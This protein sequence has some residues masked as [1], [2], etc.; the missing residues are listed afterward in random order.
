MMTTDVPF[1][2]NLAAKSQLGRLVDDKYDLDTEILGH[3]RECAA[4]IVSHLNPSYVVFVGRSLESIQVYLDGVL[5]DTFLSDSLINLNIS[6]FNH[7][8]SMIRAK[9]EMYVVALKNHFANIGLHPQA[10]LERSNFTSFVDVVLEGSTFGRI[11]KFLVEWAKE[12]RVDVPAVKKKLRFIGIISRS[13]SSPNAW[14]W[15]DHVD[16]VGEIPG[17]VK[18]IAVEL[19]FWRY[20]GE[21]QDKMTN[22]ITLDKWLSPTILSPVHEKDNI[23]ALNQAYSIYCL[24]L[25]KRERKVFSKAVAKLNL[26]SRFHRKLI[27]EV[28]G[29]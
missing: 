25:D 15:N 21:V 20:L 17:S 22:S 23:K 9:G 27:L 3:V 18:N 7:S 10:I 11:Y 4:N 8:I 16:W 26:Q 2:W 24:G 19:W 12:E 1:R 29:L 5:K 14:R 28:K 13:K 6:L